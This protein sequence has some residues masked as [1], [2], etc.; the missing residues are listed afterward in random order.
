VFVTPPAPAVGPSPRLGVVLDPEAEGP[1][2]GV[3]SVM[4]GS[5][6]SLAGVE[7]GDRLLGFGGREL[8]DRGD[9]RIALALAT[10]RMGTIDVAR[11]GGRRELRYD[12]AWAGR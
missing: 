11:D 9:L 7:A 6:A 2:V 4:P 1:G 3:K 5:L 12:L 10:E 8:R